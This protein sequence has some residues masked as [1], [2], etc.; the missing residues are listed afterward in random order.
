MAPPLE[1]ES[2]HRPDDAVRA[3]WRRRIEAEYRS[4]AL[5]QHLTLWL[6][7]LGAPPDLV[8]LG[9]RVV[10]DELTHA[11]LSGEVFRAAG[12]TDAPSIA[13]ETLSLTRTPGAPLEQDLLRVAVEQFCLGET[14]AVRLFHRLRKESRVDIVS[15]AL[16]RV[17]RDE[18]VHRD[19]GWAMLE[20][21]LSTALATQF[22]AQLQRELPAMLARVRESY[23][24]LM[25]S[26]LG[27]DG[28]VERDRALSAAA[29]AW[30]MMPGS[31]Y[32]AAVEET[33]ARDY[34]PRFRAL[35]IELSSL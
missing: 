5:T 19:F 12:G 1:N 17:L 25:L 9:L 28:M 15:R 7:Q 35:G 29:R 33:F 2:V 27:A 10:S 26:K 3:E 16:R 4:A 34:E 32:L 22:R 6:I 8:T 14:V 20:W 18:A 31:E 30:G 23:G 24:G 13:R 11:E 21:L